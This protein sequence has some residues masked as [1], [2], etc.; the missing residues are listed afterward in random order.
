M[1]LEKSPGATIDVRAQNSMRLFS[2]GVPV[3]ASLN[4]A[5]SLRAHW[6]ALDWWFFTNCAS[7]STR[8]DQVREA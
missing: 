8:P 2:R 1:G 5:G 6:Y 7:S 3:M 4:A